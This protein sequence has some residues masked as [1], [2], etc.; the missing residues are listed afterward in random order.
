MRAII[1]TTSGGP[2]VLTLTDDRPVPEP[3]PGEVRVMMRVS[4]VNPTDWKAR[5]G[6]SAF[7]EQV[8]NQDGSG[9]VD[10]VGPGVPAER[11]G[12]R[13]WLWEAAYQRP[14][15]TAQEYT[16][17]PDRQATVLPE[18]ASFDL[19]ACLGIPFLTAHRA[20][21]V[22]DGGPERL[23]PGALD[24]RTVLV[25]GGAGLVG[26]AAIQL[27]RWAGATV[28][29]TVSGPRKGAL[30]SAAGA[31]HVVDYRERDAATEILRIAP[32][33]VHVVVEVAPAANTELDQQ[34]AAR[35]AVVAFY[36]DDGGTVTIPTRPSMVKNLRWQAVMVYGVPA[37]AKDHAV[38]AV[39]A[40][41]ADD[42]L[43]A[44]EAAGLPVHHFPLA[45]TAAAHAA[46]ESG[47]TV[48]RVLITVPS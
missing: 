24:G 31:Q 29:A 21:T 7:P 32:D 8:P 9:V 47:G 5:R 18:H 22:A 25:A 17:V 1:Y 2:D 3:G 15:G 13:V 23:A 43:H 45:E 6:G 38:G 26:N 4:G 35:D 36:A 37:A 11:V 33:G 28:V 48:G 46:V 42:A 14:D 16:V 30:A 39:T 19:G 41:L 40:A 12:Q 27:A 44:G 20:L 10:A 34:V